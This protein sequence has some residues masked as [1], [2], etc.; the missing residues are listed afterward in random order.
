[1]GI[2]NAHNR[3]TQ[4]GGQTAGVARPRTGE[5]WP[6]GD[7]DGKKALVPSPNVIKLKALPLHVEVMITCDSWTD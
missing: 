7:G 2:L 1:M 5:E 4:H 3:R 6:L